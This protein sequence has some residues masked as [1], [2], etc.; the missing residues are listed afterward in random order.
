MQFRRTRR[1]GYP[2]GATAAR[3]R[4]PTSK[5]EVSGT[6]RPWRSAAPTPSAGGRASSVC[7]GSAW[8]ERAG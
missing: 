7:R 4:G 2:R 1:A 8:Q 3:R 6:R 5:H